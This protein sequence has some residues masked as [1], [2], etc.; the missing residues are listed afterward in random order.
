MQILVANSA[1]R[2]LLNKIN[3]MGFIAGFKIIKS[4]ATLPRDKGTLHSPRC[5]QNDAYNDK[6]QQKRKIVITA[7]ITLMEDL[8]NR[9]RCNILRNSLLLLVSLLIS[10]LDDGS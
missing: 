9:R 8:F 6:D 3:T 7:I 10:R 5:V 1:R 4:H 2:S